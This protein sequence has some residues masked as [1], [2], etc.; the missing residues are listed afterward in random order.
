MILSIIHSFQSEWLKIKR[1]A[2]SWLVIIGGGFIPVIMLIAF[3]ANLEKAR[4]AYS[5][6]KYWLSYN[7]QSWQFMA[8]FLLPMG[9]ILATSLITQL[10]YKNNAWKQL[11]T[12]PQRL[13]TIF[14]TKLAVIIT[15]MLQFF[16]FF[17]VGIY[18]SAIIPC[19]LF[20][21]VLFP[22]ESFPFTQILEYN[23]GFFVDCLPIIAFQYLVSLRFNNFLVSVG[24]GLAL[25]V[26]SMFAV[27]WQ[28][29]YTFPYTYCILNFLGKEAVN[30]N[31][32]IQTNIHLFGWIYFTVFTVAGYILYITKK[33]KG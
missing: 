2:A 29:G 7:Q 26:A 32:T 18:L 13:S 1:S 31:D 27:Q 25:L 21:D 19:L 5:S 33:E 10:E 14:F 4:Q 6:G 30:I 23:A 8:M 3:F 9:V 11:H 22:R 12:T 16:L 15:M 24:V 20:T 28:Y 17:N